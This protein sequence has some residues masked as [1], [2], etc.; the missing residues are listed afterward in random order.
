MH[1]MLAWVVGFNGLK[2]ARSY[3]QR[4]ILMAD[5]P[6]SKRLE[7]TVSEVQPGSGSSYGTFVAA[8][9]GLVGISVG[10]DGIAFEIGWQ[11]NLTRQLNQVRERFGGWFPAKLNHRPFI[12]SIISGKRYGA[13]CCFESSLQGFFEFPAF[14]VTNHAL[15]NR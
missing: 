13:I 8:V 14:T 15:P 12:V 9:D 4:Q 2:G 11:G 3:V 10:L 6:L 5:A 1:D 7:H